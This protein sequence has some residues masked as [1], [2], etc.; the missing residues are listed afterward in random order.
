MRHSDACVTLGIY[1]QVIG[2]AQRRAV[3]SRAQRMEAGKMQTQLGAASVPDWN[4]VSYSF[5]VT[6]K[7]PKTPKTLHPLKTDARRVGGAGRRPSPFY[8]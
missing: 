1:G 7:K 8:F 2:E 3:E 6:P 5:Y 4:D